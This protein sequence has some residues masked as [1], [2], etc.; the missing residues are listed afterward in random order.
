MRAALEGP[1]HL[2]GQARPELEGDLSK[3]KVNEW[4]DHNEPSYFPTSVLSTLSRLCDVE[5]IWGS[6]SM[7][8]GI[9]G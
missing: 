8:A 3:I 5:S 6:L 7:E 1:H 4:Q 9:V 2:T